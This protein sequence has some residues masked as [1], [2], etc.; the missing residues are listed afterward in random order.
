V[1]GVGCRTTKCRLGKSADRRIGGVRLQKKTPTGKVGGAG[2]EGEGGNT[3]TSNRARREG[4]ANGEIETSL[5]TRKDLFGLIE[6][7]VTD[8]KNLS[9]PGKALNT[10]EGGSFATGRRIQEMNEQVRREQGQRNKNGLYWRVGGGVPE[11]TFV[12]IKSELGI[13]CRVEGSGFWRGS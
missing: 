2:R 11:P 5:K 7:G 9:L 8:S 1:L 13:R 6:K 10:Q 3:N 4:V 12:T